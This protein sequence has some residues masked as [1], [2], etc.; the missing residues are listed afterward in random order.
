MLVDFNSMLSIIAA[1]GDN[2]EL[3]NKNTLLWHIPEDMKRFK[4]LTTNHA[5]IMGR[6]TFESIGKPLPNRLN[7]VITNDL[8]FSFPGILV[9]HSLN[10]AISLANRPISEE[11]FII[12]GASIYTQAINQADKLYLTKVKGTFDADAFFPDYSR[13]SNVVSKEEKHDD[14]YAYTFLELTP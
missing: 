7:I 13:F 4:T 8:K 9:A 11:L 1:I 14:K 2:R 5:V 12:G 6:K 3:G 10:E